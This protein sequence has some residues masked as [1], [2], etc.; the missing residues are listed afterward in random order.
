M[1]IVSVSLSGS[2]LDD[3]DEFV[4]HHEYSGRSEAFR[5]GVRGLLAE[6]DSGGERGESVSVVA[7]LFEYGSGAERTLSELRHE[8]E[9]L[10]ETNVHSCTD[11]GCLECFVVEGPTEQ[12]DTFVATLR[13]VKG[14][15][16]VERVT[17]PAQP[18]VAVPRHLT[19]TDD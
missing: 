10:L 18:D 19:S 3:L 14:V 5:E 4:E 13:S 9:A 11:S 15:R 1:P 2:L 16:A 12:L 7:V 6:T 17:L 8:H